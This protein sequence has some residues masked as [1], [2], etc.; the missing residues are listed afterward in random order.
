MGVTNAMLFLAV[1]GAFCFC[2]VW[3]AVKWGTK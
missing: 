3:L 2:I 1:F